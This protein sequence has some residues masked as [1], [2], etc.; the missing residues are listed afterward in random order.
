MHEIRKN[1]EEEKE[2]VQVRFKVPV[3]LIIYLVSLGFLAITFLAL[4]IYFIREGSEVLGIIFLPI[5]IVLLLWFIISLI[6][7]MV[8]LKRRKCIITNKRIEGTTYRYILVKSKFSYRLDEIDKVTTTSFLGIHS[9]LLDFTQG[10]T[11]HSTVMTV[12]KFLLAKATNMLKIT[13]IS[14]L[15]DV[16]EKLSELINNVKTE[17]DLQVDIEMSK[18]KL[19][20]KKV[21]ALITLANSIAENIKRGKD[22]GVDTVG[23]SNTEEEVI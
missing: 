8:T 19:E 14:N 16:Y 10:H 17:R 5:A 2:L 3:G 1:N 20:E 12:G 18:I 22:E 21:E 13:W 11:V 15:N 4:S 7:I 23:I 6:I 9:I